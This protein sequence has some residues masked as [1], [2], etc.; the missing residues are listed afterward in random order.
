MEMFLDAPIGGW[1]GGGT[2]GNEAARALW[3]SLERGM[4]IHFS[5]IKATLL[6]LKCFAN[7]VFNKQ[8]FLRKDNIWL[9]L[10]L[11]KCEE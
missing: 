3:S 8:I 1:G 10:T 2:C 5:E 7:T 11:I 4:H 9:Q 6:T